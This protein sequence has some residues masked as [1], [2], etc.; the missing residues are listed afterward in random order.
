MA[1]Q[2]KRGKTELEKLIMTVWYETKRGKAVKTDEQA[3]VVKA[4]RKT[5]GQFKMDDFLYSTN[6][7]D[8]FKKIYFD[9]LT[10]RSN[11][12]KKIK[13]QKQKTLVGFSGSLFLG[14][15]SLTKYTNLYIKCVEYL[16]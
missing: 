8:I 5:L 12:A 2:N 4:I 13:I 9:V 1:R 14:T 15:T 16:F 6:H 7:T 10:E 3:T 11:D